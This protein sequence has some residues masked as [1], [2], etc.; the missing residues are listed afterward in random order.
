MKK[1][2]KYVLIITSILLTVIIGKVFIDYILELKVENYLSENARIR[3]EK[4][5]ALEKF[6][7]GDDDF[8]ILTSDSKNLE[9]CLANHIDEENEINKALEKLYKKKKEIDI[10][11]KSINRPF[12]I[13]EPKVSDIVQEEKLDNENNG[14]GVV[15]QDLNFY[16]FKLKGRNVT[17]VEGDIS[18]VHYGDDTKLKDMDISHEFRFSDKN[19]GGRN[20]NS[21]GEGEVNRHYFVDD[22]KN[23]KGVMIDTFYYEVFTKRKVKSIHVFSSGK[24]NFGGD[25]TYYINAEDELKF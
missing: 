9:Y 14:V 18:V 10:K 19:L 7:K 1:N 8:V 12:N 2:F 15:K 5:Q 20:V 4:R 13:S 23:T 16:Q 25:K 22:I 17:S 6:L 24:F 21:R 11:F 3:R